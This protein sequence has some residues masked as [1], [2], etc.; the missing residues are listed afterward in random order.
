M[1]IQQKDSRQSL[2]VDAMRPLLI[3]LVLF[4]HILPNQILPVSADFSV[5]GIYRIFSELVSH[6]LGRIAVPAFF[7]IS[8]YYFFVGLGGEMPDFKWFA[9]KWK[10]RLKTLVAPYLLWNLFLVAGIVIKNSLFVKLGHAED[11]F[12]NQIRSLGVY[13]VMWGFPINFPLWYLRDLIVMVLLSPAFYW[14][15]KKL[16]YPALVTIVLVYLFGLRTGITGVSTEAITFFG[17]GAYFGIHQ[18]SMLSF[19]EKFRTP[20]YLISI[21]L[22]FLSLC[23][24]AQDYHDMVIHFACI[25]LLISLMNFVSSMNDRIL[26]FLRYFSSSVFFIY[27]FHEIYILNWTKGV[28]SS[29]FGQST[30]GLWITYLFAPFVIFAVCFAFYR[31]GMTLFPKVTIMLTGGRK[32]H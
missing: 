6:N 5:S 4:I 22:V 28:F 18:L 1:P 29:I 19:C 20:G 9:G 2:V 7:V 16:R 24:N 11:D 14:F 8:G 10:K 15:I 21:M 31:L 32:S 26:V 30:Y 13:G 17:L 23:C 3:V 25:P 12:I 27:A